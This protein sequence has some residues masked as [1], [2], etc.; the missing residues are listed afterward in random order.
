MKRIEISNRS[1]FIKVS[2]PP[3]G[4]SVPPTLKSKMVTGLSPVK[5]VLFVESVGDKKLK[6]L[7]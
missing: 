5:I 6:P 3:A 7:V 1:L 4:L 2:N